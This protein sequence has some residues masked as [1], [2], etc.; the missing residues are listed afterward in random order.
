MHSRTRWLSIS[1]AIA[2]ILASQAWAQDQSSGSDGSELDQEGLLGSLWVEAGADW[3]SE[4]WWRGYAIEAGG[5]T[6]QPWI[7]LGGPIYESE[8]EDGLWIEA[9]GGVWASWQSQETDAADDP[10]WWYETDYYAGLTLGFSQ[11]EFEL[12]YTMYTYP[13]PDFDDVQEIGLTFGVDLENE[14]RFGRWIGDPRLGIFFELDNSNV[15]DGV[16][17]AV[18]FQLDL[19]PE[20]ELSDEGTILSIPISLGASLDDY[21]IDNA[22]DDETFGFLQVGAV[23]N[24]PLAWS[25][26]VDWTLSIGAHALFLGGNTDEFNDDNE[27][28]GFAIIGL[29]ASF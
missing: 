15:G 19:G 13:A 26:S 20:F 17:E 7:E 29:T 12:L 25:D 3:V 14:E 18:Y 11:F 22:G 9:F 10:Q 27:F 5:L 6:V 8:D 16:E 21:Y 28:D 24:I 23:V 4:Y 1:G 2:T